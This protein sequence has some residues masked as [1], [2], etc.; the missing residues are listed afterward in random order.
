MSVEGE[1]GGGRFLDGERGLSGLEADGGDEVVQLFGSGRF[2]RRACGRL[3]I[4]GRKRKGRIRNGAASE[5]E[6]SGHTCGCFWTRSNV[7]TMDALKMTAAGETPQTW[8][9]RA[10]DSEADVCGEIRR[11]RTR[12]TGREGGME[13][14]YTAD[15][16]G[17]G[18]GEGTIERGGGQDMGRR[19]RRRRRR[20][21]LGSRLTGRG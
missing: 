10:N 1:D 20:R 13:R 16:R 18:G 14:Q 7:T 17:M 6:G 19:E 3:L 21:A 4:T 9:R 5:R 2:G 11:Q 12:Y 8:K 15:G